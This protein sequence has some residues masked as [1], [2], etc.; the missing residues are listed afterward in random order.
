MGT[1]SAH[2]A[3]CLLRV[4]CE[5]LFAAAVPDPLFGSTL[6]VCFVCLFVLFVLFV[7]LLACY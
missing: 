5:H 6:F 7:C 1:R 4:A 2:V 3:S